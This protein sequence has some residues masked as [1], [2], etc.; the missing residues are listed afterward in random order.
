MVLWATASGAALQSVH[1]K[2]AWLGLNPGRS[3]FSSLL[4]SM[5]QGPI[6]IRLLVIMQHGSRKSDCQT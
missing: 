3:C 6:C 2:H 4:C 5:L 1:R